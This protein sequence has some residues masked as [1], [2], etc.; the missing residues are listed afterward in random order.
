M[1]SLNQENSQIN[2]FKCPV[3]CFKVF[4]V[5]PCRLYS[6]T[7][8]PGPSQQSVA[9]CKWEFMGDRGQWTEYQT[10]V[11]MYASLLIDSVLS[12]RELIAPLAALCFKAT[13]FGLL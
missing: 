7:V 8:L 13:L 4:N 10:P 11:R 9:G 5:P 3:A 6:T 12:V 1:Y 2:Y